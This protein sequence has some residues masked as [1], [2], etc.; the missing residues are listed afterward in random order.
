MP[1]G[2]VDNCVYTFTWDVEAA[3]ALSHGNSEQGQDCQVKDPNSD[4]VFNLQHLRKSDG[5]Y[6][7]TP[8]N[9]SKEYK[10]GNGAAST[11]ILL[12]KVLFYLSLKFQMPEFIDVLY[13]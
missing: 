2:V 7:V 5:Y 8:P 3:C 6:K 11:S 9:G 4:F 10:V 1:S 13:E 12:S